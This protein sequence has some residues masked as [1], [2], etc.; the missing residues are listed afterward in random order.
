MNVFNINNL[1]IAS[2]LQDVIFEENEIIVS[3]DIDSR[4]GSIVVVEVLEANQKYKSLELKDDSFVHLSPGDIVVSSLGSRMASHGMCGILPNDL[5]VGQNASILNLGGLVGIS[6]GHNQVIGAATSCKILGQVCLKDKKPL[7]VI[8]FAKIK[9]SNI[10]EKKVPLIGCIGSAIDAGKTSVLSVLIKMLSSSGIS[11]AV[12]KFTGIASHRDLIKFQDSG[13]KATYSFL[14]V[15]IVS[16]C[17][18]DSESVVSAAKGIV[19]QSAKLDDVDVMMFE[20]GDSPYGEYNVDSLLKDKNFQDAVSGSVLCAYD[21]P[22]AIRLYDDCLKHNM[23][24]MA[25]SGPVGNNIY[26]TEAAL[27]KMGY[28]IPIFSNLAEDKIDEN[29]N[30]INKI[31]DIIA[32]E[33]RR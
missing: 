31:I 27:K 12:A 1:K 10:I 32:N 28:D 9:P 20:L 33:K 21:I 25:L 29:F 8:D 19:N 24:P 22:G 4:S 5:K 14:D 30:V 13:A 15:G 17:L 2:C 26:T 16:T 3:D 18:I 7:N 6:V 11:V 23:K